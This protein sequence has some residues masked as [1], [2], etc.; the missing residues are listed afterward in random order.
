MNQTRN[1]W[2]C[3]ECEN[4]FQAEVPPESCPSCQ[5]KCTFADVTCYVPECGGPAN[6]DVR[7]VAARSEE[8]RKSRK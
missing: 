1:W 6:L 7:L 8:A 4:V 5:K 2:M 3:S